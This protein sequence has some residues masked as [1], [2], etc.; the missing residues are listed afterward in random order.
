N[1]E[2]P[3]ASEGE[4][5][6]QLLSLRD[7]LSC[8]KTEDRASLYQQIDQLNAVIDQIR[9]ARKTEEVD[10]D[11]PY[12][13]HLRVEESGRSRDVFLGRATRLGKG[14]RIV[15]WRNAPIS[16][17][18]YRYQEGDEYSEEIAGRIRDGHIRVRRT[19]H[20]QQ[21]ELLRV[22]SLDQ[23]WVK[24][25]G[26]WVALSDEQSRLAGGEG[27]AL[28][29]GRVDS[30]LGSGQKLRASKH[31]PD[32]AA[33]ID[34]EQFE[35][36]TAAQSGV[37]VLRGSAGSGKTT[38]AL[39]RIAFLNFDKPRRFAAKR[40]LVIV[41]GRAMK[42]YVSHV[43]PALGVSGVNVT[44]WTAWART[45]VKRH[46]P[47]L[48][49][50]IA[51]DTPEPVTRIKLHPAV[52]QL[53]ADTI[54]RTPG[55]ASMEQAIDDWANLLTD[56]DALEKAIGDDIGKGALER[57]IRWSS[58]QVR[59]VMAW[60]E[61]DREVDAQLDVEDDAL[62]LRAWQLRVGA[63]RAGK[64][65]GTLSYAHIVLD[66]VQ[67][68]SPVEVQ[69]LLETTDKHRSVTLAGDTRQHISRSAGFTDWTSF[70]DRIGVA[71]Q[72]LSTLE[73][74]YRS[75]HPITRFA[76]EVLEDASEPPP[77]TIRN[78]PPV[79]MFRFSD[80]G[81]AVAFLSEALRIVILNEPLAN[82][83][84]LTPTPAL[85]A[86]YAAGLNDAEVPDVRRVIDQ[87]FAFAPGV[88][89][90]EADQVKGL[91]FDY[92][93]IVEASAMHWPDTDHH[94]RLMHV[95][96]T[97]AVHQL[98]LTSVATPTSILPESIR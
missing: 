69:V 67:D 14:L 84:L 6:K 15:D 50:A 30:R 47:V 87:R 43:L 23:S 85:S 11:S 49:N 28:R 2:A 86:I 8:A 1:P 81:A 96:A 68:F 38:V 26:D 22:G 70:L 65:G 40:I 19:L 34:P 97:R 48:P 82:I 53:L 88:D 72:A 63:L 41:W 25:R 78:G 66:E 5:V 92:V 24:N 21:G 18:F 94:R 45:A 62:L 74:S 54:K 55:K 98:W 57:A 80:H 37:V 36:I 33:L 76:L 9:G 75:T 10:P 71:S 20:I 29:S 46:F 79:E 13:A 95:A 42:D 56:A 16:R 35:L 89:V 58:D 93:I 91:E 31:L 64:S 4:A 77:R 3:G 59:A 17:I 73:V 51:E 52:S 32:I 90:V 12:F 60:L 39:H 7:E 61:G 27:S 83:A 44:T